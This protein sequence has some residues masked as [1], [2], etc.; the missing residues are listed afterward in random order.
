MKVQA[1]ITYCENEHLPHSQLDFTLDVIDKILEE[2][3]LLNPLPPAGG[4]QETHCD[5]GCSQQTAFPSC[6]TIQAENLKVN[7]VN[8]SRVDLEMF[9]GVMDLPSPVG[10]SSFNL[11][12][13]TMLK[14]AETIQ[15]KSMA[16]TAK[17]EFIL[18]DQDEDDVHLNEDVSVDGMWMMRGRSSK[19]GV[20]TVMGC[21]TG[22][23]LATNALSKIYKSCEH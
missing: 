16:N 19:I 10:D 11:I 20:T 14:A 23:V 22:K 3:A 8:R 7:S 4:G 1:Y 9:C 13:Q 18:A 21:E 6:P 2:T 17:N 15:D 5:N 12:N